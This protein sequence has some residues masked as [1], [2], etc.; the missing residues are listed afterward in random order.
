MWYMYLLSLFSSHPIISGGP[1]NEFWVR[2]HCS[3]WESFPWGLLKV[4]LATV[5]F[6][7]M[8]R[9]LTQKPR[10]MKVIARMIKIPE[11]LCNSQRRFVKLPMTVVQ[12]KPYSPVV[13][14]P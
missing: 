13:V 6:A 12:Q 5:F 14:V 2:I 10:N 3:S 9:K 7:Y 1:I 8:L 4:N 11:T